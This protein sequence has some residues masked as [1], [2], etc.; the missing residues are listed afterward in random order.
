MFETPRLPGRLLTLAALIGL[1]ALALPAR[2]AGAADPEWRIEWGTPPQAQ[3]AEQA[4]DSIERAY[5]AA[6]QLP[7]ASPDLKEVSEK[8]VSTREAHARLRATHEAATA[9][10]ELAKARLEKDTRLIESRHSSAA[11]QALS[12]ADQEA[13]RAKEADYLKRIRVVTA[14][15]EAAAEHAA[16]V[17]GRTERLLRSYAESWGALAV[18]R[19]VR[20][21][22]G[23]LL[24]YGTDG[25]WLRQMNLH[26]RTYNLHVNTHYAALPSLAV[27]PTR[28]LLTHRTEIVRTTPERIATDGR[29]EA[30]G[31]IAWPG[32]AASDGSVGDAPMDPG[33]FGSPDGG[34]ADPY[35]GLEDREPV[36]FGD[37]PATTAGPGTDAAPNTLDQPTAAKPSY[38]ASE[39]HGGFTWY[40]KFSDA[41]AEA[42]RTGKAIFCMSTKAQCTICEKI[43]NESVPGALSA[44][45]AKS[46]GYL[47]DIYDPEDREVDRVLRKG[48]PGATIMP[49]A[50]WVTPERTWITGF[51]GWQTASNVRNFLSRVR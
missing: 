36:F 10:V 25:S 35:D 40:R 27:A 4:L 14:K 37:D 34:A 12:P 2:P 50:G 42:R 21:R 7:E 26:A 51:S 11:W 19:T 8:L 39:V 28:P 46:V 5:D 43:K 45:Q 24:R 3:A 44:M 31:D 15:R 29:S 20:L 33:S 30:A 47:Y 48:L 6:L 1:C 16:Q 32:A 41:Q 13:M 22:D 49:L 38:G 23:A 18:N 9:S 17:R